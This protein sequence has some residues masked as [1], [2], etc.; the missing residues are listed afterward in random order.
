MVI[1]AEKSGLIFPMSDKYEEYLIDESKFTGNAESISFP[2]NE[3]EIIEILKEMKEKGTP[4]TI[5]GG[6]TGIVGSAVPLGGHI[7]NLSYMNSVKG[8]E[9]LDDE[10]GLITV[11]SG[12]NLIDLKKEILRIFK[13]KALFWPPEPTETS[14][15]VGGICA[16]NAQ[17]ISGFVYGNVQKYI[18]SLRLVSSNGIINIISDNDNPEFFNKVMGK[19]G[20]T[21]IISEVTLKLIKKPQEVWGISFFFETEEDAGNFTDAIKNNIPKSDTAFIGAFEYIDRNSINLIEKRKSDMAKIKE[22][23]DIDSNFA[24]MCY[25]EIHGDD[26]GIEEIAGELMETAVMYNS[27]PDIAWAVSGETEVEKTRAFRHAAPE[28]ANLFIEEKRRD[29]KRITK[30]GT[31]MSIDDESFSEILKEY[32][33]SLESSGLKGCVF[34]HGLENHLHVNILPENYDEYV[35]GVELI[36]KWASDYNSKKGKI[37]CEHGIGKLKKQILSDLLPKDYIDECKALKDEFDK[38][39]ILNRGNIL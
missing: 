32:R 28:T 15:T 21:G 22:L 18:K 35:K 26:E 39:M 30:L 38:D 8:Y 23:P 31:D 6:K 10:T 12:I 4:V 29:D 34:G 7:M 3:E 16:T 19:E 5:Q 17:G 14:A 13:E 36:R 9:I 27:D 20:I 24:G 33:S 25:I 2:K 1:V 37:I 11:E